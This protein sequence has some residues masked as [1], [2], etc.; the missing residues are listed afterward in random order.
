MLAFRDDIQLKDLRGNVP[1]RIN[2]L[3][4]KQYDAI[5]VAA[6][7]VER[8]NIDLNDFHVEK[9]DPKEF[10]PAPAQGVLAIQVKGK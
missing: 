3:K 9:L 1:T 7:G 10:I 4:E 5:L 2:K 8:L 6:A